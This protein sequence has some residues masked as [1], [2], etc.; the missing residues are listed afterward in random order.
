[1]EQKALDSEQKAQSEADQKVL[2]LRGRVMGTEEANARLCAQT[3]RQAMEFS[4]LENFRVGTYL[5][6]FS[7]CWFFPSACF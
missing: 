3:S 7:S 6:Y 2:A 1:M 5:F 4:V